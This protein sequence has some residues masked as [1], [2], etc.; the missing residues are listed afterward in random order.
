MNGN[1]AAAQVDVLDAKAKYLGHA[2][3]APVHER[4]DRMVAT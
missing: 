1:R 3:P 4:N 2:K